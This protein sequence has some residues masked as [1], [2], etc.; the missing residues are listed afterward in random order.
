MLLAQRARGKHRATD[1]Q[2]ID[3]A[4]LLPSGATTNIPTLLDFHKP[5]TSQE[6]GMPAGLG[7]GHPLLWV[8]AQGRT[9]ELHGTGVGLNAAAYRSVRCEEAPATCDHSFE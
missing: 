8:E 6:P 9:E 5:S 4:G 2:P 7:D 1:I 3:D